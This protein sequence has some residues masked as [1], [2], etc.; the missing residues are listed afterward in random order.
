MDSSRTSTVRVLVLVDFS[1]IVSL[2]VSD[3][4]NVTIS[5]NI[6]CGFVQQVC[7][8]CI[9]IVRLTLVV[10]ESPMRFIASI[11]VSM[12]TSGSFERILRI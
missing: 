12:L 9:T 11:R 1:F 6:P 7:L 2:Y 10:S 3:L 8:N 5:I 4:L